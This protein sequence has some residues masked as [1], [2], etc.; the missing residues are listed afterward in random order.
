MLTSPSASITTALNRCYAQLHQAGEDSSTLSAFLRRAQQLLGDDRSSASSGVVSP[1]LLD[2]WRELVR[3]LQQVGWDSV[4]SVCAELRLVS[5]RERC[6]DTDH[7]LHLTVPEGYPRHRPHY[8]ATLPLPLAL[9]APSVAGCVTQWRALVQ[10]LR[11]FWSVLEELDDTATVLDPPDPQPH[12]TH[13]RILLANSVSV[14]LV[15][16]PQAPSS[17]PQCQL[18]GPS[19]LT[20]PLLARLTEHYQEWDP[21]RSI[22][23]NLEQLLLEKVVRRGAPGAAAAGLSS[24][25]DAVGVSEADCVVCYSLHCGTELP[26]T[27]CDH[28]HQHMHLS[29]L[30]EWLSGLTNSRQSMQ[31]ICGDCP[32]C[33]KPISCKVPA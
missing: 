6:G 26:D 3:D 9:T 7:L 8:E 33:T 1:L 22:V 21:D 24:N 32:Y 28:C 5:V 12:H 17:A 23:S 10:Q 18:I 2:G 16:S 29:C 31:F 15:L 13:R 11:P 4:V 25:E 19:P 30:Y 20:A 27:V 14:H